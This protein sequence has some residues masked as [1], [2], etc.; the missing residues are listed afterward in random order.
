MCDQMCLL[1]LEKWLQFVG[2][3][4]TDLLGSKLEIQLCMLNLS[5]DGEEAGFGQSPGLPLTCP[6]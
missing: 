4:M 1:S 2:A 5:G 3:R 6:I